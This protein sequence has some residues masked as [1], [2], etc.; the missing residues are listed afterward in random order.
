[1]SYNRV[2]D[3]FMKGKFMAPH[4]FNDPENPSHGEY[5]NLQLRNDLYFSTLEQVYKSSIQISNI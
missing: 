4:T 2:P 3:D 5:V 1:M